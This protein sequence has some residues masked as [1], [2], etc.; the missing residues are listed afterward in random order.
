MYSKV[1]CGL[2]YIRLIIPIERIMAPHR[3]GPW[4]G[5]MGQNELRK[6]GV[7]GN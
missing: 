6:D 4:T 2:A 1:L 7:L 5:A 3:F